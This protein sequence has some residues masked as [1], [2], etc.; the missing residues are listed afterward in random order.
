[1]ARPKGSF[2]V[3]NLLKRLNQTLNS[4]SHRVLIDVIERVYEDSGSGV[5]TLWK[6][7]LLPFYFLY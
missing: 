2:S 1:M 5:L 6:L 3:T 4:N 7:P